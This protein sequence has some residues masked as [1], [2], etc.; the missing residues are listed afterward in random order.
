VIR[1]A[2]YAKSVGN[3]TDEERELFVKQARILRG[4]YHFEAWRMWAKIPY[5]SDLTAADTVTNKGDARPFIIADIEQGI[6]LPENMNQV[7]RFNST[8][9]MV[10]LAKAKM[11]MYR[12]Y[13]G[14]LPLLQQAKNGKKPN[15]APIGLAATY[16]EVFDIANRNGIEAVYTVQYSVNDGSGGWNGGW[17][18]VLNFPYK[19]GGSPGGCCGFLQPTQEYVNS[20]R[21]SAGLPLLDFSYN[22]GANQIFRDF[23]VPAAAVWDPAKQY[24]TNQYCTYYKPGEPFTDLVYK[25]LSGS[26]MT[27][28]TGNN[29]ESSPSDWLLVWSENNSA[30]VDP[31]LDWSVGR[32]GIPYWD[33]GIHTGSDWV[34]D[35]YYAGPYSPKKNVYKKTDEGVYTEKGSWT[36][37]FT[38]NGYRMIRYADLL[39]L[40]AECQ[41]ETGDLS[42]ARETVNLVRARAANPAGFVKEN[43]NVTPAANY[44]VNQYPATGFPFD[45][46]ENARLALH[47]ER[48]LELGME[49]HRYFDLNRWGIT[50][51]ELNRALDYEISMPWG[52]SMYGITEVGPEDVTY[53]IP[54][55]QIDK[56]NG[57]IKQNR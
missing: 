31:R 23:G 38:A 36:S 34:R 21:T 39:L 16:G 5:K 49:G 11:Q 10:L 44:Q 32:R 17:G 8:V 50:V 33:W 55:E 52:R 27:P 53:P 48:K 45:S 47:M 3:I 35:Q 20:F 7:G 29:P 6:D 51:S 2:D 15:G 56:S 4:W 19:P 13:E 12:D 25:S 18:D 28:N 22:T 1:V 43:D 24:F 46:K 30:P 26:G 40:L 42:G 9:A 41:L 54:Q 57:R 37:G 14:A